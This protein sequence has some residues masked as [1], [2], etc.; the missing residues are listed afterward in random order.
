MTNCFQF[1]Y[2][3]AFNFNLRR[4]KVV[5][6]LTVIDAQGCDALRFT[7]ATGTAAA[8]AYTH[9]LFGST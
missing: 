1:C 6:P 5:D 4:Y 2:N 9:P 8:G 3:F 7:L